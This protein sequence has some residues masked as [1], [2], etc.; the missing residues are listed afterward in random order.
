MQKNTLFHLKLLTQKNEIYIFIEELNASTSL[1]KKKIQL[2]N[3]EFKI[4][5]DS[6]LFNAVNLV[7]NFSSFNLNGVVSKNNN[8]EGKDN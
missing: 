5:N 7:Y 4:S 3:S 1:L 6:L 2:T 8:M